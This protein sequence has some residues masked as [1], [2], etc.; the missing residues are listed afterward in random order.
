ME[1]IRLTCF[2]LLALAGVF[3]IAVAG[4]AAFLPKS[5]SLNVDGLGD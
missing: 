5:L 4:A 3:L 1:E 2:L